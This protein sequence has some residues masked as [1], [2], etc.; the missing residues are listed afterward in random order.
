M[1]LSLIDKQY[2]EKTNKKRLLVDNEL[3]RYLVCV[4][5]VLDYDN[6]T[7]LATLLRIVSP[8]LTNYKLTENDDQSAEFLE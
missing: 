3:L 6:T 4:F 7:S 8:I 5:T 2:Y 1:S